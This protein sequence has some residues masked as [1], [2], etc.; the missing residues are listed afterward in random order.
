MAAENKLGNAPCKMLMY[1][2]R[3]L[4]VC[5]CSQAC[6]IADWPD[7]KPFCR[8]NDDDGER[9]GEKEKGRQE[10]DEEEEEEEEE[11]VN[12]ESAP[13]INAKSAPVINTVKTASETSHSASADSK[14][15]LPD[16]GS[17]SL[18]DDESQD[19]FYVP[20]FIATSVA[21]SSIREDAATDLSLVL[22]ASVATSIC[23]GV[24]SLPDTTSTVSS[25]ISAL[26]N[27]SGD[28]A[29]TTASSAIHSTDVSRSTKTSPVSATNIESPSA[30]QLDDPKNKSESKSVEAFKP[31][32]SR[33]GKRHR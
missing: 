17:L 7:H 30:D 3:C 18:T 12:A 10:E 14:S 5:Y 33:K 31:T 24:T 25:E 20:P 32:K 4:K 29:A 9:K 11:D 27:D 1:C 13:A 22:S 6:Q 21:S 2:V 16:I 26:A 19:I 23:E 15:E 28:S 8:K